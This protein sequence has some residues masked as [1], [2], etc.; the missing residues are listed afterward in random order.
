MEY[1][2]KIV[3]FDGT[4]LKK[5]HKRD[6]SPAEWIIND[7]G[8]MTVHNGDI[9]CDEVY[10]DALIHLEFCMPDVMETSDHIGR[11]NSGV[12]IHGCYEV[13]II[14]VYGKPDSYLFYGD[15][16]A[17][18]GLHAP[19]TN[20]CKPTHEWQTY[21]ILVRAPRFND[22]G[23]IKEYARITI[24]QNGLVVLNNA[25]LKSQTP[26][27]IYDYIAAEGPLLLQDHF[28]DPVK[29]RNVWLMHLPY[30]D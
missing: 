26:A 18:Y 9:I 20:A 13:Q 27:G 15:C 24:L 16:G 30:N 4:D 10:S 23:S 12:Y 8:S 3:L 11:A 25:E 21:D 17:V 22:D 19:L 28:H 2:K 7:D 1:G 6:G 29:F 5:W 14:D